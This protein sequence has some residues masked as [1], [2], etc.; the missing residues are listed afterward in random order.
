MMF[1]FG[2]KKLL[3][4]AIVAAFVVALGVAPQFAHAADDFNTLLKNADVAAG[5]KAAHICLTC[6]SFKK[7]EPNKVG[8]NLWEVVG[9][10][11]ARAKFAYSDVLK[12][13]T[14]EKW[15]YEALNKWLANPRQFAAGTK[16]AFVGIP[17]EKTRADLIAWLRMQADKPLALPAAK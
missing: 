14:S 2:N 9:S 4:T 16:M 6:H 1:D 12:G 8:P 15:T 11:R 7:G 3:K 10:G 13:M 5:E 17:D